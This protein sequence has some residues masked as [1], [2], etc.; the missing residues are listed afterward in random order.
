MFVVSDRTVHP[1]SVSGIRLFSSLLL[2]IIVSVSIMIGLLSEAL[3]SCL[4]CGVLVAGAKIGWYCIY[5][6]SCE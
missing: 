2:I 3:Y 5:G 1:A 6:L 4:I